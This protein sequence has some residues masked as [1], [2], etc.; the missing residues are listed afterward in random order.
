MFTSKFHAYLL[1]LELEGRTMIRL[2]RGSILLVFIA[3]TAGISPAP[4]SA[5]TPPPGGNPHYSVTQHV[6]AASIVV[7]GVVTALAWEAYTETATIQ[8]IQYLKSEGPAVLAVAGY[9]PGSVCLTDVSVGTHALFYI[10][11]DQ[12]GNLHALQLSQFDATA[13]ADSINIAE[14]AAASG[15]APIFI[16]SPADAGATLTRIAIITRTSTPA[17]TTRTPTVTWSTTP[18]PTETPDYAMPVQGERDLAVTEAWGTLFTAG[19]IY[20]DDPA[21]QSAVMTRAVATI[22]AGYNPPTDTPTPAPPSTPRLPGRGGGEAVGLVG[23]GIVIGLIVGVIG[24]I[25]IG[26]LFGRRKG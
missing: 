5:C 24:G 19:T 25:L 12:A 21:G 3:V 7:E 22:Q 16:L 6:K 1:L 4:V 13:P 10:V 17:A 26:L 2:V 8:V 20:P 18:S 14:A 9:G 23:V 11:A 15:Q